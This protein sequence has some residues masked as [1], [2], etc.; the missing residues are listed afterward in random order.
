MKIQHSPTQTRFPLLIEE[1][2]HDASELA[3]TDIWQT[4]YTQGPT[5]QDDRVDENW[6]NWIKVAN[7]KRVP[8]RMP[9]FTDT[10]QAAYVRGDKKQPGL[11]LGKKALV[12][13]SIGQACFSTDGQLAYTR[14]D[15][16]CLARADGSQARPI[17]L[18]DITTK[19]VDDLEFSPDSRHLWYCTDG[20]LYRYAL[21]SDGHEKIS[22]RGKVQEFS[23]A[24]DGQT[25]AYLDDHNGIH[26]LEPGDAALNE[27]DTLLARIPL[28]SSLGN[29]L[30]VRLPASPVFTPDGSR[31]LFTVNATH[32]DGD[33]WQGGESR[34]TAS[35][36]AVSREGGEYVQLTSDDDNC[37][38]IAV[39]L[40]KAA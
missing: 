6:H 38:R 29:A 27:R 1:R 12:A 16:L 23:V 35:L 5:V 34:T 2:E 21:A 19:P 26:R 8:E 18:G 37:S 28:H 32:W 11:F 17:H 14:E 22:T 30:G 36:F 39:P 15:G 9:C 40:S 13:G 20:S 33:P 24:P 31:V 25:V 3:P 4:T 7:R 10:G